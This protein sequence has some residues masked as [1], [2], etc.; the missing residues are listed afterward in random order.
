LERVCGSEYADIIGVSFRIRRQG[1]GRAERA[2]MEK[3]LELI[4]RYKLNGQSRWISSQMNRVR[5]GELVCECDTKGAFMQPAL[6]EAFEWTVV[7]NI[8]QVQAVEAI[9]Q[10]VH[11]KALWLAF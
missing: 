7:A 6:Y 9:S 10:S 3:M 8:L 1:F 11:G 5:N 4:E 2:E